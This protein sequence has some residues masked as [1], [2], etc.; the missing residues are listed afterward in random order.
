MIKF[1]IICL[2][3]I[4]YIYSQEKVLPIAKIS[5]DEVKISL[6][7]LHSFNSDNNKEEHKFIVAEV[8]I[9]NISD[10]YINMG[11]EYSMSL[12]IIDADGKEYKSGIK[13]AAIVSEFLT[14]F[15]KFQQD[16]NAYNLCF[17]DKF[18]PKTKVRSFLCGYEVPENS[19]IKKFGVKKK[20]IF[21][22]INV[23]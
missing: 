23:K 3:L 2:T 8:I 13:G 5:N 1:F 21:A 15:P 10:K 18:P 7:N 11:S 4:S 6:L 22:S 16:Q 14:K 9:E 20:N 12:I 19:Q 17:S